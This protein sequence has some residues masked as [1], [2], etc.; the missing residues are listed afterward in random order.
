MKKL[1]A[2]LMS[3]LMVMSLAA[4]GSND[5]PV[6]APV[7]PDNV[8]TEQPVVD[9]PIVD[10]PVEDPY[11]DVNVIVG[12]S[13]SV[14]NVGDFVFGDVEITTENHRSWNGAEYGPEGTTVYVINVPVSF[15]YPE[16][17]DD[18]ATTILS[19]DFY[20]DAEYDDYIHWF[21][22]L[23]VEPVG[24]TARNVVGETY[25]LTIVGKFDSATVD[26]NNIYLDLYTVPFGND[27]PQRHFYIDVALPA[28][29]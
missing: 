9:E 23:Y 21:E 3:M 24:E 20:A 29:E 17:F 2:L 19:G 26:A 22:P 10:E 16:D 11:S 8:V 13:Y 4:C 12:E 15:T 14:P 27:T 6:E 18:R 5:Q 7:E 1:I 28:A 25:E